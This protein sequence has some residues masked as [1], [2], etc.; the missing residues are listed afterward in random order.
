MKK[1]KTFGNLQI[2]TSLPY[3]SIALENSTIKTSAV[4]PM[5]K[6]WLKGKIGVSFPLIILYV[7]NWIV[8]ID[9]TNHKN[10]LDS[11]ALAGGKV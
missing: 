6:Q 10:K 9:E 8:Q 5:L 2:T 4:K 3:F 7:E 11:L 1:N